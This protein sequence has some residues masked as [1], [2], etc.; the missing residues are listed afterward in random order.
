MP[1]G[2]AA[3]FKDIKARVRAAQ[4]KAGLAVNSDLVLLYWHIGREILA[5]QKQEGW[6]AKVLDRLSRDL[7]HEFPD[8]KGFSPRN[9]LFMRGF[10]DGYAGETIVKQLVSLLPWG[11]VVRLV[12][13]VKPPAECEWYARAALE[14]GSGIAFV[15]EQNYRRLSRHLSLFGEIPVPKSTAH[16]RVMASDCDKVTVDGKRG[17]LLVADG[18]G[19]KRRPDPKHGLEDGGPLLVVREVSGNVTVLPLGVW[20]GQS[21]IKIGAAIGPA[22]AEPI[23]EVLISDCNPGLSEGRGPSGP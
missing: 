15:A 12:Q 23:A 17:C 8:M 22:G 11:H 14:L 1:S 16:L 7:A 6:G 20:S 2:Y 21:W 10:A 5:R 9:L 13:A 19:Y 3:L 18:T 4:L